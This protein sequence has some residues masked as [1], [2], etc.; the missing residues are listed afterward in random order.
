MNYLEY[1]D[2]IYSIQ[3]FGGATTY[4]N[5]LTSRVSEFVPGII[6]HSVGAKISRLFSPRSSA[7]VFHSSH[8]RIATGK[9]VKNVTTIYDLIYEKSLAG[10]RGKLLNLYERKRAVTKADAIICISE[11]T[12]SDMYEY[13]GSL[14][15]EKPV[16]VIHLGCS[17][18][19]L[20]SDEKKSKYVETNL[21]DSRIRSGN[22]FI[23]VGGRA[24]Y[25]NFDLFLRAFSRGKFGPSGFFIVCTGAAF[26]ES[27]RKTSSLLQVLLTAAPDVGLSYADAEFIDDEGQQIGLDN[28]SKSCDL[29]TGWTTFMGFYTR[30]RP[31]VKI[32]KNSFDYNILLR[33]NFL[34]AMSVMWRRSVLQQVGM[35]TPGVVIEDWDL[36]LRMARNCQSVYVPQ[37]VASYRWHASNSVKT[38]IPQIRKGQDDILMR[39]LKYFINDPVLSKLIAKLVIINALKLIVARQFKVALVRLLDMGLWRCALFGGGK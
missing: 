25:K 8:F 5:E 32:G 12:R 37:V 20:N 3:K 39:E 14:I 17:N 1:D 7:K 38:L 26:S 9:D 16:Y 33:G 2:V 6:K 31:E 4:W 19:L 29:A 23:F 34:P 30:H 13:Y 36:W 22:F 24:A 15:G 18:G 21:I 10:G 28:D 27:E 11:S 35:F